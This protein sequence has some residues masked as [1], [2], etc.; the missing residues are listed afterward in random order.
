MRRWRSLVAVLWIACA[1]NLLC[2]SS[3]RR[4]SPRCSTASPSSRMRA[5]RAES[6]R[7]APLRFRASAVRDGRLERSSTATPIHGS[8]RPAH[9]AVRHA[10]VALAPPESSVL[11]HDWATTA[12]PRLEARR[13][14][15]RAVARLLWDS[16]AHRR[17]WFYDGLGVRAAH[18][19]RAAA[20]RA[21]AAGVHLLLQ[22][23][24][25]FIRAGTSSRPTPMRGPL[26]RGRAGEG[27]VKLY[28]DNAATLTPIR[29]TRPSTTPIRRGDPHR[30][31]QT[32]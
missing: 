10:A 5:W 2:C 1:F 3:S 19:G 18:R 23:S 32:T 4:S 27:A 20:F 22:P 14:A 15:L 26:E 25:A 6:K 8:A 21:G 24:R 29:C 11:A 31:P 16:P 30:A 7:C 17:G 12:P 28:Q 9:R 13:A